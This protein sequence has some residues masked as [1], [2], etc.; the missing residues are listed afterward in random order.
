MNCFG[1]I[2][3]ASSAVSERGEAETA[4]IQKSTKGASGR[5][6]VEKCVGHAVFVGLDGVSAMRTMPSA[7]ANAVHPWL[8]FVAPAAVLEVLWHGV[9]IVV[10][11]VGAL[12]SMPFSTCNSAPPWRRSF[13]WRLWRCMS[14]RGRKGQPSVKNGRGWTWLPRLDAILSGGFSPASGRQ[15]RRLLGTVVGPLSALLEVS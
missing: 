11:G 13:S 12:H 10:G 5:H 4:E 8:L 3:G 7:P 14:S 9:C 15:F 1:V 6:R 2:W